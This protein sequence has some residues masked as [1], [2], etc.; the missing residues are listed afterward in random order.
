MRFKKGLIGLT[1]IFFIVLSLGIENSSS[2]AAT[3]NYPVA[4]VSQKPYAYLYNSKGERI[5]DRFLLNNTDWQV[6]GLRYFNGG[7]DNLHQ[8][9][10]YQVSTSEWLRADQSQ[11]NFDMRTG[12]LLTTIPPQGSVVSEMLVE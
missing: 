6:N 3:Y 2:E 12:Q 4:T 1:W 7:S 11:A 10:M 5:A 8:Q 9:L